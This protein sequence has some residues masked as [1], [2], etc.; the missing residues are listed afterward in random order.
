[1]ILKK[2]NHTE[3]YDTAISLQCPHCNTFSGLTLLSIPNFYYLSRFQ[4]AKIGM[5]YMCNSCQEPIFLKFEIIR[6]DLGNYKIHINE[7]P[8]QVEFPKINFEFEFVPELVRSDFIEALTCYSIGAFNGFASMCRRTI[9]SSASEIGA[10]GKDKIQKQII[11]MKE[12]GDIDDDTFEIIKQI[13]I[14]GH[15]GAHPHLPPLSK[16]R[17]AIMFELIKDVIYQL[18]VRKGKLKKASELR[19]DQIQKTK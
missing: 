19:T 14:D 6:Y 5:G 9:Q 4:P 18:F 1:M 7:T 16:E 2:D 13:I 11:E 8:E 10:K 17:A 15:D 3:L 12:I